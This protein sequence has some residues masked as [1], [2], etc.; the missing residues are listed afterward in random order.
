MG[1][2]DLQQLQFFG[3]EFFDRFAA[4]ELESFRIDG[5]VADME[6]GIV[7]VRS[8]AG[9]RRGGAGRGCGPAV[10]GRRRAW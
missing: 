2:K 4:A 3:G 7:A 10:R 6:R 1:V 9:L 8:V 5:G